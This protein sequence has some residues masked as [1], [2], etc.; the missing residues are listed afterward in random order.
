P[1]ESPIGAT[2]NQIFNA[3]CTE[4]L[5]EL[6]RLIEAGQV[7]TVID[8]VHPLE[9]LV[10]AMKICMSHRAKGKIIIEVAKE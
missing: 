8:S 9:N 7:K 6:N 4:Y 1:I 10:E 5:L 2:Q 3:P